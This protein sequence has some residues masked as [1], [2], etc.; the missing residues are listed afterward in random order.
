MGRP[1]TTTSEK[2]GVY[3][4]SDLKRRLGIAALR[5]GCTISELVAEA[6]RAFLAPKPRQGSLPLDEPQAGSV[7]GEPQDVHER[8]P[9]T[10]GQG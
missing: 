1:L 8:Q 5:R 4:D 6:L 3:L 10:T 7:Q 2:T 9:E